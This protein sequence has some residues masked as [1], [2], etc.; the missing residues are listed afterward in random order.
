MAAAAPQPTIRRMSVRRRLKYRPSS[1]A[2]PAPIWVY[3]ASSPTEAPQPFE[4]KVWPP[5]T[6]LSRI[7]SRPPRSA[8]ASTGSTAFEIF[9]RRRDHSISPSSRP[10]VAGATRA[11]HGVTTALAL[12][13]TSNGMP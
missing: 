11:T 4:I 7:D 2:A 8:L 5:T 9:Q 12:N 1:D 3:P 6:T 10:P 13:R